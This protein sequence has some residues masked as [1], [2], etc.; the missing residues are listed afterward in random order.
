[1]RSLI[2]VFLRPASARQALV[3]RNRE[4]LRALGVRLVCADDEPDPRDREFFDDVLAL[5]P[6]E[7]VGA[8]H[9]AL[10]AYSR[11]HDVAGVVAQTEAAILPGALFARTLSAPGIPVDAAHACV[12]KYLSRVALSRAGVPT[13]AFARARTAADV[14]RFAAS[15]HGY[16]VVLKAVASSMS[17]LVTLVRDEAAVEGAV[18]TVLRGLATF[19]DLRRLATFAAAAKVDL[20]CDP[21]REFLVEAFAAGEPI[22][23]DG[24][25]LGSTPFTFGVTEQAMLQ[26]P[27]FYI[28]GYLFPSDRPAEERARIEKISDAALAASGVRDTGFSIEMRAHGDDVRVIEVNARLGQDDGFAELFRPAAGCEPLIHLIAAAAGKPP[29]LERAAFEPRAV[30][31][32]MSFVDGSVA[33]VPGP[34]AV[35]RLA[36]EGIEAGVSVNP[37]TRLFAPPNPE[38]YPHLAWAIATD[39]RSSKT[40]YARA[41]RAVSE[42]D[43]GI[44]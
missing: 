39:P 29:R 9:D 37:G 7:E 11:E 26:P 32:R 25:V 23:T 21:A 36:R 38:A 42:L 14:R 13:P 41:A 31:Y 5:P 44:A 1:M 30:A 22:E 17:R 28:E 2:L 6:Q 12:N 19:P 3:A 18:A 27:R 8:V 24:F 15:G 40:A 43:F 4:R 10:V 33:R 16:P 34:E 20:Q 35:A